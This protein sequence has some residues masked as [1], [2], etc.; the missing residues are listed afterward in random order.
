VCWRIIP[1][2]T[3]IRLTLGAFHILE[4]LGSNSGVR[5]MWD[6]NNRL[7]TLTTRRYNIQV[8]TVWSAYST[9]HA[10]TPI[11][12]ACFRTESSKAWGAGRVWTDNFRPELTSLGYITGGRHADCK[13][14]DCIN[15]FQR[16]LV[17]REGSLL[18]TKTWNWEKSYED[19]CWEKKARLPC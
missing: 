2:L 9:W 10:I 3:Y 8:P 4:V 1:T 13:G 11:A 17:K 6:E 19:I 12:S 16:E 5:R 7:A 15:P 18:L 14:Q